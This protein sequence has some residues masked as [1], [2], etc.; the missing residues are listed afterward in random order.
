MEKNV[1]LLPTL[2]QRHVNYTYNIYN[3]FADF[4]FILQ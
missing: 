1:R 2:N 4:V 3:I